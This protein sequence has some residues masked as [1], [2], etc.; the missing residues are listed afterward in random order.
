MFETKLAVRSAGG[1]MSDPQTVLFKTY[2][3]VKVSVDATP[4]N[5]ILA[6]AD[7]GSAT[8]GGTVRVTAEVDRVRFEAFD[9]GGRSIT[10]KDG[11]KQGGSR[12]TSGDWSPTVTN[13]LRVQATVFALGLEGNDPGAEPPGCN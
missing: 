4:C 11:T 9:A 13:K 1:T 5:K 6:T 7:L 8:G 3:D 12:W 10:Q 2:V